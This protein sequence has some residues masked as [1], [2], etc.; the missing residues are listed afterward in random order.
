MYVELPAYV[1]R[2]DDT[3]PPILPVP[4]CL[5]QLEHVKVLLRRIFLCVHKHKKRMAGKEILTR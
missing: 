4:S 1:H 5:T 2:F 3:T